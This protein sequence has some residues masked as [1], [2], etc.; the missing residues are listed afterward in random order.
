M[1][2][3]YQKMQSILYLLTEDH[4]YSDDELH[5]ILEEI[6]KNIGC[7]RCSNYNFKVV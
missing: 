4:G 6:K 3:P 7:S 2:N 5:I 1:R